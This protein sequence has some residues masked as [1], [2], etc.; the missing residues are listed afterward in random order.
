M[1]L[2]PGC[3]KCRHRVVA[4][5]EV[6]EVIVV[7]EPDNT[8]HEFPPSKS[9]VRG[10]CRNCGHEWRLRGVRSV[11]ESGRIA[12]GR[13]AECLSLSEGYIACPVCKGRYRRTKDGN[14]RLHRLG[15]LICDGVYAETSG[16]I[17]A[18]REREIGGVNYE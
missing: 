8:R 15:G 11:N 1:S 16:S 2:W 13:I 3:P 5:H 12:G 17:S 6:H 14:V 7:W 9:H 10:L 18:E 4:L